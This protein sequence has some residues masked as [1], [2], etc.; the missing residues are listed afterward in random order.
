MTF[1]PND[2]RITAYVLG[3]LDGHDKAA[4]EAEMAANDDLRQVVA[5]RNIPRAVESGSFNG[6]PG[7][8]WVATACRPYADAVAFGL[9]LSSAACGRNQSGTDWQSVLQKCA[10]E[11]KKSR[12]SNTTRGQTQ[13]RGE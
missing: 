3:E 13:P 1:D 5:A 9:R 10:Q 4:F 7:T 12:T 6:K 8:L 2:P 11:N